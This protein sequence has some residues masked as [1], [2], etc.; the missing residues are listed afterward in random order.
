MTQKTFNAVTGLIFAAIAVLHALRLIYG[1]PA[2]I[3]T[4]AVSL[5][6]S[7]A[8]LIIGGGARLDGLPAPGEALI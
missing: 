2:V 5:W 4:Y 7:W 8:G 3:G 1:W 6:V